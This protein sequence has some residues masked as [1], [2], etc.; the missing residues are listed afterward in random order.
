MIKSKNEVLIIGCGFAGL[1]TA[2]LLKR[3]GI[4]C[5][6]FESNNALSQGGG[7]I[8]FFSNGMNVF[9][10][11]GIAEKIISSG[12]I[13]KYVQFKDEKE[14]VLINKSI[15]GEELYGEPSVFIKRETALQILFDQAN[16]LDVPILFNKKLVD[17]LSNE[18]SVEIFFDDGSSELGSIVIGADGLNSSVRKFVLKD[19]I[20]PKYS[21]LVY[22][23]GFLSDQNFIKKLN[24]KPNLQNVSLD[25]AGVTS[26]AIVDNNKTLFWG[27]FIKQSTRVSNKELNVLSDVELI[28]RVLKTHSRSGETLRDIIS[29]TEVVIRSNVSDIDNLPN[30]SHKRALLVGDA[31]HAMNP[32]LGLGACVSLEDAHLLSKL[33]AKYSN[34]YEFIFNQFESLRKERTSEIVLAARKSAKLATANLGP[35]YILRNLALS[36]V[37]K[38]ITDRRSNKYYSYKA[39][40]DLKKISE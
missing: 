23:G 5:R 17:V 3:A 16:E 33:I 10:D 20:L 25:P 29:H 27:T 32:M 11:I 21:K 37:G 4:A 22:V 15:D 12:H 9:R 6:I 19:N 24:L 39:N 40:D 18:S 36:L 1:S 14:R 38:V 34:D 13:F 8:C 26:Y 28:D 30:W 7:A 31:A 2:V 35:F